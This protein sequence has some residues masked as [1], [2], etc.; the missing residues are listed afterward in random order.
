[1]QLYLRPPTQRNPNGNQMN[2]Q[3]MCHTL[4]LFSNS[5]SFICMSLVLWREMMTFGRADE[6]FSDNSVEGLCRRG[7]ENLC[8]Y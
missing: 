6:S 4:L 2:F 8:I 7:S 3:A 5:L 1:M